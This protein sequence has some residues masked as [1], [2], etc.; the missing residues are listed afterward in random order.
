MSKSEAPVTSL[1]DFMGRDIT[2]NSTIVYPVRR[3]SSMWMQKMKVTQIIT[4]NKVSI[5]GFNGDGR[6]ITIHNIDNVTVVEPIVPS[7]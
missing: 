4:G 5:G 6:K 1:K 3:G 7:V 2:V